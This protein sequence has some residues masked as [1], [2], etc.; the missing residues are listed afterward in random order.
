MKKIICVLISFLILKISFSQP[1]RIAILDFDNISGIAKYDGL[2]KAM[3]SMLISDIES[4][5]SPKR[6]Q[7]VERAQINKIMKEQNLQKS[8][9]FDKNTS[10]KMGKLLGVNFLLIGDIYILD[11]SLVINARLTDAS[12]G[13]I[14]FSQ[15]QE[16]KVNE[17]LIIKTKLGK[18]VSSNLKIPLDSKLLNLKSISENSLLLYA[19]GINFIDKNEIDSANKLLTELKY[20]EKEF[21]YTD[22]QLNLLFE[23]ASKQN[24]SITLKQ[25]AY[26]LNLHKRIS[27]NPEEAW[28]QI[29]TFWDGPLD[30]K[31]P[32]LEYLFLKKLYDK[33]KN[34]STWL[35][36]PISR[37]GINTKMGDIILYSITWHASKSNEISTAISYNQIREKKFP[38]SEISIISGEAVD[39]SKFRWALIDEPNYDT[40]YYKYLFTAQD[41]YINGLGSR[42]KKIMREYLLSLMGLLNYSFYD[43]IPSEY[44]YEIGDKKIPIFNPYDV[45]GTLVTLVGT[46]NEKYECQVFFTKN[47]GKKLYDGLLQD[48]SWFKGK[49]GNDMLIKNSCPWLASTYDDYVNMN[50]TDEDFRDNLTSLLCSITIK[51]ICLQTCKK[52]LESFNLLETL[53]E[54]IEKNPMINREILWAGMDLQQMYLII[55]LRNSI[56]LGKIDEI[57]HLSR[58]LNLLGIDPYK[59]S[60]LHTELFD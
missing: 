54:I 40:I 51:A 21:S 23:E 12:T 9:S 1:L 58:Q 11:N 43:Y 3:S 44:Y 27:K 37:H 32:Y 5:V 2:G 16:G 30:E 25:K 36:F 48:K 45:L 60:S 4:N 53:K 19:N 18:S 20:T 29:E 59:Y 8:T 7:L 10:V 46:E 24:V 52:D 55:Q 6:L 15:K 17:W 50:W 28:N 57:K 35:S 56:S 38:T 26:I 13:D 47:Q 39:P 41:A 34:D 14:K 42:N 49:I 22:T 31:Y 33:F